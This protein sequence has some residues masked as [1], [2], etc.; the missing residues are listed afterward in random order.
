MTDSADAPRHVL[1]TGASGGLGRA[2]ALH[3]AAPGRVLSLA[4]RDTV[5]L[6]QTADACRAAGALVEP[7]GVDV[8]DA[9]AMD[10]WLRARDRAAAID[11][12][13]ANAGLGG[14]AALAP[15]GG[16]SG[17]QARAI[18][19]VNTLGMVNTVSPLL[20]PM[21]ARGRGQVALIGSIQGGIGLPHSPSYSAS[22]AAVRVYA[23]ALRRLM[24][25]QGIAVTAVLP[26]F[27]DTPMSRS[28]GMARPWCWPADRA[29]RRIARD[30]ARRRR[31]C[32][33]PWPLRLA[34]ALGNVVPAPLVDSLLERSLAWHR[35]P[36]TG[37]TDD[38]R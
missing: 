17:A 21:G 19:A 38:E 7:Q 22:K 6:S 12:L 26:G 36:A 27:I 9:G 16:E 30:L 13:I 15:R 29:A 2:L 23:D 5:R 14:S 10:D 25:P 35:W 24:R 8:T 4:G 3:Y 37:T 20:G 33:F 1:I 31:Y 11:L 18:F 34:V 28:L 32:I